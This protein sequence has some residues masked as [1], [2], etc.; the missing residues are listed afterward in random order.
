METESQSGCFFDKRA[1]PW[2]YWESWTYVVAKRV[3]TGPVLTL[4]IVQ[5]K[6][7]DFLLTTWSKW[8]HFFLWRDGVGCCGAE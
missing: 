8:P 2:R 1:W 5:K 6:K 4:W 3:S 7:D